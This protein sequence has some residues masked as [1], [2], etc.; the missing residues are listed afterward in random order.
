M[1]DWN[2][3]KKA[4]DGVED[5][6]YFQSEEEIERHRQ[7]LLE[8]TISQRAFIQREIGFR[9]NVLEIGCGNGRLLIE[10][11]RTGLIKT[12]LGLDISPSRIKFAEAW[13]KTEGLT[14]GLS[15]LADDFFEFGPREK[16]DLIFCLTGTFGYFV[17]SRLQGDVEALRRTKNLL[18]QGGK[19]VVEL[20]HHP[21]LV[22]AYY[23]GET[24]FRTWKELPPSDPF[25][26]TLQKKTYLQRDGGLIVHHEKRFIHRVSGQVD[27]REEYLRL[28]R[29]TEFQAVVDWAGLRTEKAF[30]D[31]E[32]GLAPWPMDTPCPRSSILVLSR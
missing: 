10:L 17:C 21:E 12:G 19:L 23:R 25:S 15:F 5:L 13:A 1:P 7:G 26:F 29:P 8:K 2:W 32:G 4:Y 16:F 22:Q 31:W 11:M 24:E 14:V 30:S 27:V 6:S 9:E 20:Y 3:Y 28:Y 18:A